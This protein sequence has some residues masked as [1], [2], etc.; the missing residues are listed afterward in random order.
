VNLSSRGGDDASEVG[1]RGASG[2][3]RNYRSRD[4]AEDAVGEKLDSMTHSLLQISGNQKRKLERAEQAERSEERE[5]ALG[6][7]EKGRKLVKL[8]AEAKLMSEEHKNGDQEIRNAM[9]SYYDSVL[10]QFRKHT[11]DMN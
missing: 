9:L 10:A 2:K 1:S 4:G 5:K 7:L 3:R 8:L 6:N 11:V